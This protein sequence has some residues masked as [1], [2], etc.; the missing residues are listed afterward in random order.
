[1][2]FN[3]LSLFVEQSVCILKVFHCRKHVVVLFAKRFLGHF[4]IGNIGFNGNYFAKLSFGIVYWSK[5][6][7]DILS[8]VAISKP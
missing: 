8:L 5:R 4:Q 7:L 1:M 2:L 3:L 6:C